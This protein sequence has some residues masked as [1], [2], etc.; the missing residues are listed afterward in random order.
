MKFYLVRHGDP[1]YERDTLTE[2]GHN[3][4]QALV[5]YL[6]KEAIQE[7]VSSPLGRARDTAQYTADALGLEV[8]VE[9]WMAE[10][11]LR[12]DSGIRRAAWDIPGH[13]IRNRDYL[14]DLSALDL[15]PDMPVARAQEAIAEIRRNSDRFLSSL[16]YVREDGVYRVQR[17]NDRKIAV[18]AHGGI[19]LTWLSLLLEIPTPLFWAGF[20]LHTSSVTQIL[21]DERNA[22]FATPRCLMIS[23]LPHLFAASLEPGLAGIQANYR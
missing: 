18:F 13:E 15:I 4:A 22:E 19:G 20:F 7:V 10:L 11:S 16:G 5:T 8:S 17:R 9:P 2:D 6:R 3:E 14:S 21:F 12:V 23:A 1:D